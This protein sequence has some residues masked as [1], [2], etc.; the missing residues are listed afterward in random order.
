MKLIG[1]IRNHNRTRY[2]YFLL[3]VAVV[4]MLGN[5]TEF[6]TP[7]NLEPQEKADVE[8]F[9]AEVEVTR[10]AKPIFRIK[11]PHV[12]R[13]ESRELMIFDGGIEV[14]FYDRMGNH[15][16]ILTSDEGTVQ[17]KT[18]RLDVKGNVVVKSDSGMV[19]LADELYYEQNVDRVMSDGF[20]TVITQNDSL[21]GV[22]FS[23]APDL[24]DWIVMNTSGTTWRKVEK[25]DREE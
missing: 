2:R 11:A 16:A 8:L 20:V 6:E 22:G 3:A 14:D 13:F 1:F 7:E 9:D 4:L 17:E 5:C 23:S 24:S 25:R 21:S 10:A 19:L 15:N 18:N 12:S